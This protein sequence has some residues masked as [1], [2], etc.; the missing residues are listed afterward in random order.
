M[1]FIA[2][3]VIVLSSVLTVN[4]VYSAI[5]VYQLS[6]VKGNFVQTPLTH[7]IYRYS[8][9]INLQDM[10][11]L[12]GD[13]NPLPYRLVSATPESKQAEPKVVTDTLRFFPITAD[14]TPDTLRKLHST[15]VNAEGNNVSVIST[16]KILNNSLPEFYLVDISKLDHDVT[17][18]IVDW[19]AHANNQYLEIELEATRNF[20]D[21][22]LLTRSTLVQINQQE[23][24]VKRN[25][26]DVNIAKKDYE[27]L[28]FKIVRGAEN[29]HITAVTAEQ[30]IGIT[31]SSKAQRETWT[32]T[33]ELAKSQ[34]TAYL[35]SLKGKRVGMMVNLTSI[36]G[37][38]PSV[39]SLR[40]LGINITAIFGPEHG[41]R[42]N[43]SNG[44]E[45]ADE[46]DPKTG[47]PIISLYG[48]KHKPSKKDME[49]VDLIVFDFQ[50]VGCRFY[51]NIN[52]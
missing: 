28:R 8:Q 4:S 37:N 11:I 23:Q 34:T 48:A 14:V 19:D 49:L 3:I 12:D 20:Q 47:I 24:S 17:S 9:Q 39:D 1:R 33:G 21:W 6:D 51:T 5:P 27:F 46:I 26:I 18:L 7:D 25:H 44:G 22:F 40:S 52:A 15:Q 10:E 45:V 38:K 42:N 43:A 35:P 16:D 50:D 31:D 13:Q 29:L 36:I 2:P 30:K 41:F 32:L